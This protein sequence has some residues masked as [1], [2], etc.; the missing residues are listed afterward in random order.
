[1]TRIRHL[2]RAPITEAVI[3]FHVQ[4]EES[5]SVDCFEPL[6]GVL[7]A[8]YPK[9][10]HIHSFE[11]RIGFEDGRPVP[12]D[13]KHAVLGLAFKSA[14]ERNIAQFR[15]N[16]FTFNRLQPY[17]EWDG[18][19]RETMRLW[20]EYVRVARP[21]LVTRLATRYINRLRFPLPMPDLGRF[22]VAPPVVPAALPQAIAGFL[23]RVVIVESGRDLSAIVMQA[24]ETSVE[25]DQSIILLDI[26]AYKMVEL[27]PEDARIPAVLAD[28][29]DFKNAIFFES[30]TEEAV[31]LF[32]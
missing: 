31:R 3:D 32:E 9:A 24:L 4:L 16:G 22:L 15:L 27:S 14:D 19:F 28:L 5:P 11:A 30:I 23:T 6:R 13:T 18:I 17:T 26:D 2:P 10:Q 21:S 25:P 20:Q 7:Q 8:D 1:M 12:P 29:H